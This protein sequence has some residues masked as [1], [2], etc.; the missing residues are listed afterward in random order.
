MENSGRNLVTVGHLQRKRVLQAAE[1]VC[2]PLLQMVQG[3]LKAPAQ[4]PT[5]VYF[6]L[7]EKIQL[8]CLS[9][10]PPV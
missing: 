4:E 7:Y 5:K 1:D 6:G 10:L 9:Y 8:A 3:V 2:I